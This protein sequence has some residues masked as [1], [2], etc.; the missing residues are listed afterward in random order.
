MGLTD[1]HCVDLGGQGAF[2]GSPCKDASGCPAG[3]SC[4]S[5]KSVEG[6]TVSQCVRDAD[7]SG[8]IVCPC[9][10]DAI[11]KT[12]ST[13]CTV[14]QAGPGGSPLACSGKRTCNSATVSLCSAPS[15]TAELCNGQDDDCDGLTDDDTC[16]AVPKT[17]V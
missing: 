4:L 16:N 10:K 7:A 11:A 13:T 9:S 5:A 14:A 3:Y 1:S 15:P 6:A 2:C 17:A 8:Q 12:L